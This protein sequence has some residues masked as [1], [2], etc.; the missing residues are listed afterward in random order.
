MSFFSLFE[1]NILKCIS[2][3]RKMLLATKSFHIWSLCVTNS[4]IEDGSSM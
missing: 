3:Y 2:Q 1:H 4:Y